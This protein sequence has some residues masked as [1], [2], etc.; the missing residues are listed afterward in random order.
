MRRAAITGWGRCTPSPVLT[1]DDLASVIDTSDEWI[2]TRSG[3]KERRISHVENS[4]MAT[5]AGKR[6]LAA[7]GLEP[8]DLDYIFVATCTGDR[9]IPAMAA[10]VQA[11]LGAR[12]V[13]AIDANAGCTGFLY[14][15]NLANG[16]IATE[17]AERILLIGSERIAPFLDLE[18][19]TTA[20]LF[21]DGA[22]AAI[23][24][25]ASG[26]EGLRSINVGADGSLADALTC[27]GVGSSFIAAPRVPIRI[28]MDGGEVFKNAVVGMSA[29]AEKAI[30]DAG[31]TK[32]D[33]DLVF[34]HQ[35]NIR[36]IDA[37]VR[38]LGVDAAKVFTNIASYGNTSAASIPIAL[39]E[40]LDEGRVAPGARLVLVAF[41][42]GLTWGAAG[43][44]W[45]ERVEPIATTSADLPTTDKTGLEIV[46][47]QQRV[48]N[49]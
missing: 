48:K 30:V 13:P 28:I 43:L 19:R 45:G 15:L 32:D 23:I 17:S 31:W 9:Q 2:T 12:G 24:E 47:E 18:E 16:L 6:A 27:Q 25:P 39:S 3:I 36:I 38:R 40:A 20:V 8:S 44:V 5:L 46:L 49:A 11:N 37:T 35:A 42:A 4:E 21:G 34:P 10:T 41:G 26:D 14:G 33:V 7:A 1:N 29:A 22:G